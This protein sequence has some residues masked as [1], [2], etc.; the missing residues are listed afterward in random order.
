M[1]T[2]DLNPILWTRKETAK[3]LCCSIKTI[4]RLIKN[5]KLKTVIEFEESK[6]STQVLIVSNINFF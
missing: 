6:F 1:G 2:K 4:D 3:H 5:G